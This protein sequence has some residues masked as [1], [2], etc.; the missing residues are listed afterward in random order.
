ME[1]LIFSSV[2]V[3][4]ALHLISCNELSSLPT[5]E[6]HESLTAQATLGTSTTTPSLTAMVTSSTAP[7]LTQTITPSPTFTTTSDMDLIF[8]DDFQKAN[9]QNWNIGNFADEIAHGIVYVDEALTIEASFEKENIKW[10][11]LYEN[12]SDLLTIKARDFD[13]KIKFKVIQTTS[14][15]TTWVTVHFRI[16]NNNDNYYLRVDNN[17]AFS[18][19]VREGINSTTLVDWKYDTAVK[20]LDEV[21]EIEIIAI[22]SVFRILI[23]EKE[24]A[25]YTDKSNT[26]LQTGGFAFGL[27]S[28]GNAFVIVEYDDL[29]IYKAKP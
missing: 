2:I 3:F 24:V 4:L 23:N 1:R 27:R 29:L 6:Y 19:V 26:L 22:G 25:E 18:L 15:E 10:V 8:S 17:Q 28:T 12:V 7:A 13:L 5:V 16:N 11:R 20:P 21:N 14:P 9:E